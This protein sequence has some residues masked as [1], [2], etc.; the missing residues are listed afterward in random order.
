M[1]RN[2]ITRI[3]QVTFN[4]TNKALMEQSY[5]RNN[6]AKNVRY[7]NYLQKPST[8]NSSN[9]DWSMSASIVF[10]EQ[11]CKRKHSVAVGNRT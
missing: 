3:T 8:I 2:C 5:K 1:K 11:S 4:K 10:M 7:G 9:V 6:R